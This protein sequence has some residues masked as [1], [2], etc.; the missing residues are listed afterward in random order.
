M[1]KAAALITLF[2]VSITCLASYAAGVTIDSSSGDKVALFEDS[3]VSRNTKGTI[4]SVFGDLNVD[5]DVLGDIIVVFG[6]IDIDSKVDGQVVSIFGTTWLKERAEING[7]IISMGNL[8]KREGAKVYGHE[9]RIYGRQPAFASSLLQFSRAVIVIVFSILVLIAGF[10][11]IAAT[12]QRIGDSAAPMDRNIGR[13]LLLGLIGF[14]G[15]SILALVLFI[16]AIAPLVYMA[17][18]VAGAITSSIYFG[19]MILKAFTPSANKYA[20]FVTGILTITLLKLLLIYFIPHEYLWINIVVYL[21]F[22][23]FINALGTGIL[24]DARYGKD[25]IQNQK[26]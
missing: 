9:L 13:K 23:I 25:K 19:R 2:I 18:L 1:K 8:V 22:W 20:E 24:L 4:V 17:I 3:T 6:D 11:V 5:A 26:I 16:T 12:K 15:A 21:L 10:I 14:I 7:D